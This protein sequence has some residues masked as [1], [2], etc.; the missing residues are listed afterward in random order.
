MIRIIMHG[1]RGRMGQA[2]LNTIRGQKQETERQESELFRLVA[3]IDSNVDGTED[4]P[5]FQQLDQCNVEADVLID[6]SHHTSVPGVVEYCVQ[7][8]LPVV[9]ATTGLDGGKKRHWLR[10]QS[11]FLFFIPPICPSASIPLPN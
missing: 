10:L 6:F 4:Y 3:G 9:I 7:K 8:N 2:I 11:R 5:A 1:C